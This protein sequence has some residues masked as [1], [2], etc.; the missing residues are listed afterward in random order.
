M[1]ISMKIAVLLIELL[2]LRLRVRRASPWIGHVAPHRTMQVARRSET[3]YTE[4]FF[5]LNEAV[6]GPEA[7]TPM[8]R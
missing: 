6:P 5:R 8:Q 1:A 4:V 7:V 2:L 3:I